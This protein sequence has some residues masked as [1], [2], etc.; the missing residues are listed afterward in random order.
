[1]SVAFVFPGQ[2]SQS[3]GMLAELA[4]QHDEV[5]QTFESASR[6]LGY[7]L[8]ALA[9]HGPEDALNATE[10]TQPAMLAAGVAVWRAWQRAA[11]RLPDHDRGPQPRRVHRA[12]LRGRDRIP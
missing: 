5:R 3:I 9:Q 8:W 1:M 10:C 4:S 12:G 2:G 7:D 11:A 6:R